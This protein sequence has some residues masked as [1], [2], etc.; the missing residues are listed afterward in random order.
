M[1]VVCA[2]HK[3]R[4]VGPCQCFARIG[5]HLPGIREDGQVRPRGGIIA[6]CGIAEQD[7]CDLLAR[8]AA[9]R[10]K[11]PAAH[12]VDHAVFRRPGHR[13][14]EP[15]AARHVSKRVPPGGRA[16]AVQT[17]QHCDEHGAR[18]ASVRLERRGRHA[19]E[20]ALLQGKVDAC[21]CPVPGCRHI[22][23]ASARTICAAV[24]GRFA[25][26]RNDLR[27]LGSAARA[28]ERALAV[29]VLR[30]GHRHAP[31]IPAVPQRSRPG[32]AVGIAAGRAGVQRVA[33]LR[34]SRRDDRGNIGVLMLLF[35]DLGVF[36]AP[37]AAEALL[38][39]QAG[40]LLR[41]LTVDDPD[42]F[43][44]LECLV[45]LPAIAAGAAVALRRGLHT[46]VNVLAH[47]ERRKADRGRIGR[48]RRAVTVL[49]EHMG[50]DDL[51]V[52]VVQCQRVRRPLHELR[53][54]RP[55]T[56]VPYGCDL[57]PGRIKRL[58]D[59]VNRF[60]RLRGNLQPVHR[61]ADSH[62]IG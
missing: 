18:H 39:L 52:V 42:E 51:E 49:I 35:R 47:I 4:S 40:L 3:A 32:V 26:L 28:G 36:T 19:V 21:V 54:I 7:R 20:Q 43:M 44:W 30:C 60:F 16:A 56:V 8:H 53:H 13:I 57:H 58:A 22:R 37:V 15:L 1:A 9:V 29:R 25:G 33:L 59:M 10:L 46:V 45:R 14:G 38:M 62:Q 12:A 48:A 61:A 24:A 27:A 5:A 50:V 2:V 55:H 17:P 31:G 6:L 11:L 23:E 34:A 41:R